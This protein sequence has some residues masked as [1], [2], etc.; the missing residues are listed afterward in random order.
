[1]NPGAKASGFIIF[2]Y[3]KQTCSSCKYTY[4]LL[5]LGRPK[6]YLEGGGFSQLIST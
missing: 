1:M 6:T 2:T 4:C 3:V 5:R